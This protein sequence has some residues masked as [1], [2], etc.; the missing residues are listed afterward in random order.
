MDS[1]KK[2]LIITYYWPP[3]AGSG[4]QRWLKFTKFLPKFGWEPTIFTPENPDFN[5]TDESLLKDIAA[6]TEVIRYPIWEPYNLFRFIKSKPKGQKVNPFSVV[7][8]SHKS[9]F[10]RLSIWL[11]A[12]LFIPDPRVFWV[13]PSVKFLEEYIKEHSIQA[14]ITTSPPHSLHLIGRELKR[15]TGI[16]WI[17]D[18]RDPWSGWGF[19]DSLPMSKKVK[20]QHQ[21]L[22]KSVLQEASAVIS[23][24]PS[25]VREFT[26]NGGREVNLITNGFDKDDFA[27]DKSR[28]SSQTPGFDLVHTGIINVFQ[29]PIPLIQA[30]KK[31]FYAYRDPVRFIF[32]GTVTETVEEYIAGDTWLQEHVK[33]T[34]YVSHEEVFS[35]YRQASML[36]LILPEGKHSAGN[37]PGKIFEYMSTGKQ[38]IGLGNPQGDASALICQSQT[39]LV[40]SPEDEVGLRNYLRAGFSGE[41]RPNENIEIAQYSREYLTGKLADIL[42]EQVHSL[43]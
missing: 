14:I 20:R 37:I 22:E 8:K 26:K 10:D 6:S 13:K 41:A 5:F 25:F 2:V 16:P 38:I 4:V 31:E 32:V 18:F 40:F 27:H 1:P 23:V 17:A 15:K 21:K 33:V 12:N 11:R 7:E 30:F 3:S 28:I 35:Y 9:W 34:G 19:Y 36:A 24:T 42:D 29:N 43:S 39:G